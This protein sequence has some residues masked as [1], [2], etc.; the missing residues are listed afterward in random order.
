MNSSKMMI[1]SARMMGS[2]SPICSPNSSTAEFACRVGSADAAPALP[3]VESAPVWAEAQAAAR[4]ANIRAKMRRIN[5]RFVEVIGI[6]LLQPC[7]FERYDARG[8]VFDA[9]NLS[10][11]LYYQI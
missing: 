11:L 9:A 1:S 8:R 7:S 6:L 2:S 4:L 10:T 3:S 5:E